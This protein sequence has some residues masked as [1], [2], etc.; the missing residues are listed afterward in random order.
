M[1]MNFLLA[2]D[3]EEVPQ[4]KR[5][6]VFRY[7]EQALFRNPDIWRMQAALAPALETTVRRSPV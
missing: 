7:G 4:D 2:F 1:H 3:K 6:T 5:E